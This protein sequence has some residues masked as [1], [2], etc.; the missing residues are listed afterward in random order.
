MANQVPIVVPIV[1]GAG[2]DS[3]HV[4]LR[5]IYQFRSRHG[6]EDQGMSR[7]G[8][9]DAAETANLKLDEEERR[10]SEIV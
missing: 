9:Y 7:F 1:R 3:G 10:F 8:G 4:L 5:C 6:L 2:A